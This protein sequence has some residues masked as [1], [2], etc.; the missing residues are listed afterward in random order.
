MS[1]KK[2]TPP[3]TIVAPKAP[4]ATKL[5]KAKPDDTAQPKKLSCLDAAAKLLGEAGQ[6]MNCQEMIAAMAE[7]GYWTSPAGKTPAQTLYAAILREIAA[8]GKE[9]RFVKSERGKFLR[10]RAGE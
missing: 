4:K 8:K 6:P 10:T 5:A 9:S 2:K 1:A 7:R 3:S